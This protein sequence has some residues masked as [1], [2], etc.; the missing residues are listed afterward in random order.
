[1]ATIRQH[2]EFSYAGVLSSTYDIINV[3]VSD[4]MQS[5]SLVTE[6]KIRETT[7]RGK[8]KPYFHEV[9]TSPRTLNLSFAFTT[10]W[11]DDDTKIDILDDV[12]DWL[13]GH[14]YYQPLYFVDEPGRIYYALVVE[15]PEIIHNCAND[16][17]INLTFR[18]DSPYA[19]GAL[20]TGAL[21]DCS[22]E[23]T[24]INFVNSGTVNL[25]PEMEIIKAGAGDITITNVTDDNSQ[26][27][28]TGLAHGEIIYVDN[29]NETIETDIPLTYRYS[30][31]NDVFLRLLPATSSLIVSGTC[32]LQFRY[33]FKYR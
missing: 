33:Q 21:I 5:E 27:I 32:S 12:I 23:P 16:G 19:Y 18:C 8:D 4:G 15:T 9:I 26:F 3:N 29:E 13:C 17:Y 24:S 7:I 22:V 31:H 10:E 28:L 30:N 11:Y 14:D 2:T 25:K 20:T 1:M 6:R